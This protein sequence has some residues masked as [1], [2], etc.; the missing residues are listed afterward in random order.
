[1]RK[2]SGVALL[3]YGFAGKIL[4]APLIRGVPGLEL[5][6]VLSSRQAEVKRDLPDVRVTGAAD[7]VFAHPKVEL[8]VIATPNPTHFDRP[9]RAL[10]AGK[11]VVVDKPFTT[12]VAEAEELLRLAHD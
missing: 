7:E 11:H 2:C 5:I 4:H 9:R 12:T 8:V 3:G 10:L 6:A 1:M